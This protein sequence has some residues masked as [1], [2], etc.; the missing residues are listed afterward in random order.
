M[1]EGWCRFSCLLFEY[2]YLCQDQKRSFQGKR[3]VMSVSG[4]DAAF[5][6]CFFDF[7]EVLVDK[8]V[9][10][11]STCGWATSIRTWYQAGTILW[12]SR[13]SSE[14]VVAFVTFVAVE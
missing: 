1:K 2:C 5:F 10:S 13:S 9:G 7:K 3:C 12:F 11:K 6:F 14:V 4:V 8:A